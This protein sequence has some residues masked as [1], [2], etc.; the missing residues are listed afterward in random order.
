M[1]DFINDI[2]RQY[3]TTMKDETQR[4]GKIDFEFGELTRKFTVDVIASCAF[5]IEV[6]SFAD[7]NNSF[8][9]LAD[10]VTNVKID[11]KQILKFLGLM[12]APKLMKLIGVKIFDPNLN[13]LIREVAVETMKQR[14]EKGI[15]RHDMIHL[16]MQAKKGQLGDANN[17]NIV[18]EKLA[19]GFATAEEFKSAASSGKK[20]WDDD[21]MAAQ[22][23]IFFL[24]GFSTVRENER[25][26]Q[27]DPLT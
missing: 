17:N 15:V 26:S 10:K 12:F 23:L 8:I 24:A 2:S 19:D 13:K 6:N 27:T 16:L 7:P 21:D 20:V 1:F 25:G 14:E 11:I 3:I 4:T 18:E 5:G 9:D 22:C